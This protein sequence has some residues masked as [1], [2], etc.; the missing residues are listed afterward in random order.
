MHNNELLYTVGGT[1]HLVILRYKKVSFLFSSL[2]ITSLQ[3]ISSF[4]FIDEEFKL[5]NKY[6]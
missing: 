4:I 2:S 3:F 1:V 5:T 6:E